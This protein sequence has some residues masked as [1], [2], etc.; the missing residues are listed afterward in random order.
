MQGWSIAGKFSTNGVAPSSIAAN[1]GDVIT[2]ASGPSQGFNTSS[3]IANS[4][5]YTNNSS[6]NPDG[7]IPLDFTLLTSLVVK[8]TN[9]SSVVETITIS[10]VYNVNFQPLYPSVIVWTPYLYEFMLPILPGVDITKTIS[11]IATG[12]QLSGSVILG[13]LTLTVINGAGIYIIIPGQTYDVIYVNTPINNTTAQI[14]IS[15]PT[16]QTGFL[17]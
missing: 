4:N 16:I 2:I 7:S 8:Y 9:L 13:T 17:P 1:Y 15:D 10:G 3:S 6:S 14:R 5:Y 11:V 12:S